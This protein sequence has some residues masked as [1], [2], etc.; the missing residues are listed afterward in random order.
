MLN[1]HQARVLSSYQLRVLVSGRLQ[2]EDWMGS[3]VASSHRTASSNHL[4]GGGF[5]FV[6]SGRRVFPLFLFS[7]LD[8][9]SFFSKWQNHYWEANCVWVATTQLVTETTVRCREGI[10]YVMIFNGIFVMRSWMSLTLE[11]NYDSGRWSSLIGIFV[12]QHRNFS[13]RNRKV[14]ASHNIRLGIKVSAELSNFED[15][16]DVH[17][18]IIRPTITRH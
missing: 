3:K 6:S 2:G 8:F 5:T 13:I 16:I 15:Q 9:S 18:M 12:L 10:T 4:R 7:F 1:S 11:M 17:N 14:R